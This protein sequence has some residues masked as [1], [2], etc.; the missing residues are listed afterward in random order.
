MKNNYLIFTI[1]ILLPLLGHSQ[2]NGGKDAYEFLNLPTSARLTGLGGHLISVIDDDVSLALANPATLSEKTHNRLSFAH[3]F[4]FA[5]INNGSV[6]YGRRLA[7]WGLNTHLGIQYINY[8]DFVRSNEFGNTDGTFSARETAIVIGASKRI[9]DRISVGANFKNVFSGLEQYSSYGIGADLGL[10]Y[11]ND[12]SRFVATLLVKNLGY[13]V[14]TYAGERR[15][16]PLDIQIGISKRLKHLP[17]RFSIIAHHLNRGNARYDDPDRSEQVDIFGQEISENKFKNSVDNVFSH[18]IF[19]GE[20]MLGKNQNLRLRFGYNHQRR[21]ELS[22]P[23][24]RSLAGFGL[25][26]GIKVSYFKL[27]YG[28]GYHHLAGATNHITISTDLGR[29]SKKI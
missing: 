21:R 23:A 6:S 9:A 10:I 20:F 11:Y 26:F 13:E 5:D 4:H 14:T 7:K 17:L 16:F 12:S 1:L 28:V 22:L 27:D 25:G 15:G 8:G 18:L 2:I 3:N 24:F 29:F 19:N